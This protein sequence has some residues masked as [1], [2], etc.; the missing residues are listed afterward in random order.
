MPATDHTSMPHTA[1]DC[2]WT[3]RITLAALAGLLPAALAACGAGSAVGSDPQVIS[4]EPPEPPVVADAPRAADPLVA[5][6]E[7]PPGTVRVTG[8]VFSAGEQMSPGR[9]FLSGIVVAMTQQRYDEFRLAARGPW[10]VGLIN[11]GGFPLPEDL[12]ADPQVYTSDLDA[13]GTYT[14]TIPP[15]EYVLCLGDISEVRTTST[16]ED[17]IWIETVFAATVTE[18]DLQTII[19]VFNRSTGELVVHR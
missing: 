16:P 3:T 18:Q 5:Y 10:K 19:P 1:R 12:L 14:L 6:Y 8:V 15:G 13:T 7:L 2:S 17:G 4:P 9:P 11:G